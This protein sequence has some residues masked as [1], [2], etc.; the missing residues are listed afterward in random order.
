MSRDR[1]LANNVSLREALQLPNRTGDERTDVRRDEIAALSR[2]T[3][4][5]MA[6]SQIDILIASIVGQLE[7]ISRARSNFISF[8]AFLAAD[9]VSLRPHS[10]QRISPRAIDRS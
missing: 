7:I 1:T 6:K 10:P 5:E 9:R 4:V 2:S 3:M 8:V